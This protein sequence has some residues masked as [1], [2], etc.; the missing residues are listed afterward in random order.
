[1]NKIEIVTSVGF[2]F[3]NPICFVLGC[4]GP[5]ANM[6]ATVK[7]K[8]EFSAHIGKERR[9]VCFPTCSLNTIVIGI[10]VFGLGSVRTFLVSEQ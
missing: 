10:T 9:F 4:V 6:K 2:S 7:N 1:M 3:H 8:E 5:R